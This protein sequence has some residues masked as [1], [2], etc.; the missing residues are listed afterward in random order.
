[1][2]SHFLFPRAFKSEKKKRQGI[3]FFY[4]FRGFTRQHISSS[5]RKINPFINDSFLH[6]STGSLKC[7]LITHCRHLPVE[8]KK[9][10]ERCQIHRWDRGRDG[11]AVMSR[12]ITCSI[13]DVDLC[14]PCFTM[15][16][17]EANITDQ[18]HDFTRL[19]MQGK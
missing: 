13:W 4:S 10:K 8:S 6:P 3:R 9:K 19:G 14:L 16:H 18:R 5:K 2:Q 7:C 15:F 12:V 17:K 1:M 11:L